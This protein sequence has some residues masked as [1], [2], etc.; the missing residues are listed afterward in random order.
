MTGIIDYGVGNLHSVSKA[1][2][3]LGQESRIVSTGR[4]F[5]ACERLILPGVGAFPDA[6][7][8]LKPL[9]GEVRAAV[10]DGKPLLG[11]C[12]G[13]QLLFES[14]EECGGAEGLGLLP[15]AVRRFPA[16]L[17]V[18]N[19]GWAPLE[20]M[21]G[22]LFAGVEGMDAYFVHSY[23]CPVG[24]FTA[25]CARHGNADGSLMV[26]FSAAVQ[27]GRLFG[28]QF[29]PEKSGRMGL[30]LIRNFAGVK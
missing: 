29:H 11:I 22:D 4:E 24:E 28:T 15:G 21:R 5:A 9:A 20:G 1:L 3:A 6:M 27:Q 7:A 16:G 30:E 23:F 12:L 2:A 13:M 25:A 10:R 14:S 26:E 17:I 19:M 8:A 18:P